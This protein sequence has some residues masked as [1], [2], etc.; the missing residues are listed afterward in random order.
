MTERPSRVPLPI[1]AD[2]ALPEMPRPKVLGRPMPS[3]P[4]D[5]VPA[6]MV[7]EVLYC[8]RLAYL[9]WA[10]SEFTGNAFTVE[11]TLVHRR[12]DDKEG[13]L[14]DE[15]EEPLP[16]AVRSV[17]LSSERLGL[18]A[19][20]DLIEGEGDQAIAVETKRGAAPEGLTTGAYLPERA[21]VCVQVLLLRENGYDA[22]HGEI[23][24]A[25]SR[26]RVKIEI[27]E[28]LITRTLQAAE[29]ARTITAAGVI[30]PPLEDSPKCRGCSLAPVC[31]PDEIALLKGL[32]GQPLDEPAEQLAFGFFDAPITTSPEADPWD[33]RGDGEP[34]PPRAIRRL[35]AARDEAVPLYVQ[36]QGGRI[37]RDGELLQ[38]DS[39]GE[40]PRAVRLQ[41][42]S[43]VAVFGHVQVT[44]QALSALMERDIPLV[45]YSRGGW[46][47]GRTV[48][49]G[50]RNIELR[51]AQ[52][53]VAADPEV[54]ATIART[55]VAAKIRNQR[56]MLRR[57]ALGVDGLV[58]NE[59]EGLAKKAERCDAV[60][61]LLGFEGTAAR[62][63]FG[64]FAQMLKGT[65]G[66]SFEVD[67]RN[68]RPPRDPVN[69]LLS[70]TYALLVKDVGLAVVAVGLEPLLGF[71]HQPRYGRPAL[72]LD[73]M[74]EMRPLCA[75]SVVL[76]ALNTGVVTKDDFAFGA[77]GCGLRDPGRKR[78]IEAY[79]RRMD[80]LVTHPLFGYR[81]SYRRVLE[82]QARLLSRVI[83]GEIPEYPAF[84]TR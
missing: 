20:L 4:P 44:T 58:L 26:T 41:H 42:T 50:S 43:H 23:Y 79:E 24:F 82:V 60:P 33:L 63:Y 13:M 9:E 84:R 59:M 73:L 77:N 5:L 16:F 22:P 14:P 80:Q 19:K 29:E 52:H 34:E 10:Q 1:V 15:D 56:L 53:R 68:R 51:V 75:D 54:A 76:T 6:R 61:S 32:E 69:A 7:N 38:V 83:L 55:F 67:G 71:L 62:Y 3:H 74:E 11:G 39:G 21:Q 2:P 65:A 57:N 40:K 72:A 78:L 46:Y 47:R 45:L 66:E 25:G 28:R 36:S 17:T 35:V 8:Q 49:H 18:V 48:G 12:I 64:A 27:D 31:L 70:L 30:P 81:I 37:G